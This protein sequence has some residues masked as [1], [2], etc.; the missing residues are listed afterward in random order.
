VEIERALSKRMRVRFAE[1]L[2]V[3]LPTV[4]LMGWGGGQLI[5]DDLAQANW[6]MFWLFIGLSAA[7]AV[8]SMAIANFVIEPWIETRDSMKLGG[9]TRR[10]WTKNCPYCTPGQC[11]AY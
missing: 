4:G 6:A 1:S 10:A 3:S 9:P 8:A 7:W 2:F 5:V 11:D